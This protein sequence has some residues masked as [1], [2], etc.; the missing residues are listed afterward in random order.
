MKIGLFGGSFDPVHLGHQNLAV[1]ALQQFQLDRVIWIPA[2]ISP[3]KQ[4]S[5]QGALPEHRLAMLHL[6]CAGE[7][8][9]EVS[10][11]EIEKGG[12]SYSVE[13][14]RHFQNLFP[15]AQFFWILG[16]DA[17]EGIIRWKEYGFLVKNLTFLVAG[18]GKQSPLPA[19]LKFHTISIPENPVSSTGIKKKFSLGTSENE[20]DPRVADYIRK[21]R[22]YQNSL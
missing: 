20:L 18:R 21:N 2:S 10:A 13:T 17:L 12:I 7:S 3:F 11:Y 22:L 1:H 5:D 19:E 15:S 6:I 8:R 14:L 4:K 16:T 9:F